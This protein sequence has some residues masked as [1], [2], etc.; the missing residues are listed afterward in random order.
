[1]LEDI[2][3][4]FNE[5]VSRPNRPSHPEGRGPDGAR[6]PWRP[7]VPVPV[8]AGPADS[9]ESADH[10]PTPPVAPITTAPGPGEVASPPWWRRTPSPRS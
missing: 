5:V 9:S 7:I 10:Q 3:N 6:A 4:P 1:M 2:S 8:P